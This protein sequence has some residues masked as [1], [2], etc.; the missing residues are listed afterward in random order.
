MLNLKLTTVSAAVAAV[1]ASTAVEAVPTNYT[2]L[3][4][5][6]SV[7]KASS[8]NATS[9]DADFQRELAA[10]PTVS[11]IASQFDSEMGKAT[12]VWAP[13]NLSAPSLSA[14]EPEAR[15]EFAADYYLSAL[16]GVN[17]T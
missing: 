5:S 16:T 10:R 3:S 9:H 6:S 7:S 15:A 13:K 11:G 1:L 14:L 4:N 2:K 17:R 12:F 8:F